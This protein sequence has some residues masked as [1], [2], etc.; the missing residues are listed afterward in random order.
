MYYEDQKNRF[1]FI[2][3]LVIG[4]LVGAG[5]ALLAAPASGKRTRRQML[6]RVMTAR[7]AAGDR[8]EDWTDDLRSAVRA[9]RKRF[10]A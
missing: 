3:G 8:V 10:R 6:R 2:S 4:A 7:Q 1:N 5:I 9:G